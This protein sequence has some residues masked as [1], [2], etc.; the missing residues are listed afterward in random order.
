MMNLYLEN[1]Q[2]V[3]VISN[4]NLSRSMMNLYIDQNE[5]KIEAE[6]YH[7]HP[8]NCDCDYH[9]SI[10]NLHLENEKKVESEHTHNHSHDVWRSM[11]N[12]YIDQNE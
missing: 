7:N 12:L 8:A 6:A 4:Q 3:E 11:M 5:Q 2:K 1:E 10:L 9:R